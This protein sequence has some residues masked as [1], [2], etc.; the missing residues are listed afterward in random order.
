MNELI[1]MVLILDEK[2]KQYRNKRKIKRTSSWNTEKKIT[3]RENFVFY[4]QLTRGRWTK[5]LR[6]FPN[7]SDTPVITTKRRIAWEINIF[8]FRPTSVL[9]STGLKLD[10]TAT[11]FF[12]SCGF[13]SSV[14]R[15]KP[16][17]IIYGTTDGKGTRPRGW[18]MTGGGRRQSVYGRSRVWKTVI[19]NARTGESG[20]S[21]K[22]FPSTGDCQFRCEILRVLVCN[23]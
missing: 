4:I 6:I 20:R 13:L 23:G 2:E 10:F 16:K 22:S 12:G 17:W 21:H 15:V 3:K 1:T 11:Q 19:R 5:M 18:W 7:D 8:I 9:N 14:G